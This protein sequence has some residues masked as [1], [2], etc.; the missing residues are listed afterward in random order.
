MKP[1]TAQLSLQVAG[2]LSHF[3]SNWEV[4]TTDKCMGDRHSEGLSNSLFQSP[5][6][7]KPAKPSYI[8]HRVRPSDTRGG[9]SAVGKGC[10]PSMQ[11]S[12]SREFLLNSLSSTQEMRPVIN[13]KK[14]NEWVTP[15]H[16][17]MEGIGT[18]RELLR[19]NDWMVKIDLKDDDSNTPHASTVSAVCGKSTTLPI[20]MPPIRTLLCPMGIHQGDETHINFPSGHGGMYDSLHR[21]HTTD[22]GITRAGAGPPRSFD[23][24]F[25][26][27]GV[28]YQHAQVSHIPNSTNRVSGIVGRFNHSTPKPARGETPPHQVRDRPDNTQELSD[29]SKA[30]GSNHWE[31][32]CSIAGSLP[33]PFVLQVPPG[34]PAESSKQQPSELQYVAVSIPASP[35][36]VSLVAGKTNLLEWQGTAAST[37]DCD[38]QVGCISPGLGSGVQ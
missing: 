29:H 36:G 4:L 34:G 27:A 23:L 18:L 10:C 7:G 38:H 1:Q 11:P 14:L 5:S 12:A 16:F 21:R 3:L 13:L 15:Q 6:A 19:V 2:R 31:T 25:D 26:R 28:C 37:G 24:S 22:G 17:K 33:S 20:C 32:T 30:T 35:G 9:E 8:L